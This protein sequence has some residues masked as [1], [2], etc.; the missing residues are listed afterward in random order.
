MAARPKILTKDYGQALEESSVV[1]Q[2]IHT[3]DNSHN[4][5]IHCAGDVPEDT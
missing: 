5:G 1:I 2:D 3:N 4:D